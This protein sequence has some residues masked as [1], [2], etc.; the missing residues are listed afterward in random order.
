MPILKLIKLLCQIVFWPSLLFGVFATFAGDF[1]V[2][3]ML[4]SLAAATGLWALLCAVADRVVTLLESMEQLLA[5]ISATS[6][7][8]GTDA[9]KARGMDGKS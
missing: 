9:Q 8:A 3:G 2:G 7:Q 1:T 6:Q 5:R 4:L